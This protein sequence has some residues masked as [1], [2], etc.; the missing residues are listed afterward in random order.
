MADGVTFKLDTEGWKATTRKFILEAGGDKGAH[1]KAARQIFML[2]LRSII[3]RTPV[4]TGRARGGFGAFPGV[5]IPASNP[6]APK[7]DQTAEGLALS[8]FSKSLTAGK[9]RYTV[10][11]NV[12][13]IEFLESG[14]SFQA[15]HG[16]VAISQAEVLR[17]LGGKLPPDLEAIYQETWKRA[18]QVT[19]GPKGRRV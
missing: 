10:V 18:Q 3:F 1:N 8:K 5:K 11:N 6:L 14:S 19:S 9:I 2:W 7:V 13:Y 16:M 12:E 15:P 17:I 4:D